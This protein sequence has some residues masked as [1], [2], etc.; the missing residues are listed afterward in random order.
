M[1]E[2]NFTTRVVDAQ[3]YIPMLRSILEEGKIV[4]MIITGNSMSP[5]LISH[6]D[7]IFLKKAEGDL[8][9]GDMA[10]FRR[11]NGQY[12]FHRIWKIRPDGYYFLGDGQTEVE[13]PLPRKAIFAVA[14]QV[15]RKGQ[16]IGPGDFWWE[17]FRTVWPRLRPVRPSVVRL[18]SRAVGRKQK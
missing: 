9:V 14:V 16:L 13:G 15:E 2:Q 10:F 17:F 12:V 6:R 8:Q 4:P 5:F 18:Y 3:V 7:R 11:P 1:E